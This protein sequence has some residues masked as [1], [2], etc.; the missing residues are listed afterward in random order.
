MKRNW[1]AVP[2]NIPPSG[3]LPQRINEA[4]HF[5][6]LAAHLVWRSLELA[7]LTKIL[8]FIKQAMFPMTPMSQTKRAA[9]GSEL[10][11]PLPQIGRNT[12]SRT[13]GKNCHP[14]QMNTFSRRLMHPS[15]R[16]LHL[17]AQGLP[18]V[19]DIVSSTLTL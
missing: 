10:E 9:F 7:V 11:G 2:V 15:P 17:L 5:K 3:P 12:V 13:I 6:C 8:K 16:W 19:L 14:S 4:R 18:V 1:Q